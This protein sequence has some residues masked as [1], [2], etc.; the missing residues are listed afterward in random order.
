M[1]SFVRRDGAKLRLGE[2]EFR[3]V[4]ANTYYL[5]YV[6]ESVVNAVLDIASDANMNVLRLWAFCEHQ[7]GHSVYYQTWDPARQGTVINEGD[8]GLVRL[9]RAIALAAARGMRVILALANNWKDFGGVPEYLRW[10]GLS[11]HDDFY[12]DGRCRAAY[13]LWVEQLLERTNTVTGR[14]YKDDP[15][16]LAWELANEPRCPD[17][18]NGEQLLLSW[19]YEMAT[20][21]KAKAPNHLVA[22]GD[23]GFFHRSR[24]GRNTLFNGAHG[25]NFESILGIGAVD[26]GTYHMYGAWA[27]GDDLTDFGLMWIRE[28]IEAASRANKPVLLEEYGAPLDGKPLSAPEQRAQVYASW[29][30]LIEESDSLGDLVWMLG[31][32]SGPGQP[33]GLDS[34]AIQRGPELDVIAQHAVRLLRRASEPRLS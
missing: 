4:G 27:S 12:R 3:I 5:G 25:V 28:H 10:F 2:E 22:V 16:I 20:L 19:I 7:P 33:Y 24:A 32:P 17:V 23:E 21:I 13:W 14:A 18:P 8:T 26:F 1:S 30:S 15:T 9:D 29:L 34:Y 6:D 31:I 11:R